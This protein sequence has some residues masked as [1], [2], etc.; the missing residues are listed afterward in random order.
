MRH[1]HD[2]ALTR[3]A[4]TEPQGHPCYRAA[5]ELDASGWAGSTTARRGTCSTSWS[6]RA[7]RATSRTRCC[8]SS[9][10]PVLTLGRHADPAHVLRHGRGARSARHRGH[11]RR[12]RRRGDLSRPGP[13]GRLSHR[14]AG[15]SRPAAAA[16]RA[17]AGA[18]DGRHRR[19]LRR[20][21]RAGA[22]AIPGCWVDPLGPSRRASWAP[23]ACASSAA[24]PT[25]ASRSTSTTDLADFELIDP[26]GL[27]GARGD[28]DRPRAGLDGRPALSPRPTACEAAADRLRAALRARAGCSAGS[29][30][31][32]GPRSARGLRRP[33][34]RRPVRAAPRRHHRL[35]GGGGRR[36]GVRPGAVRDGRPSRVATSDD[37]HCQNCDRADDATASGCACSSRRRSSSPAPS[38]RRATAADAGRGSRSLGPARRRRLVADDRCAPRPPRVA[39]RRDAATIVFEMLAPRP[40]RGRRGARDRPAPSTCQVVQNWGAQAGALTD[41]LCLDFYDLP[42]IPHRIGEELGGAARYLIRE[43]VCPFCRLVRDEVG[44]PR[45]LVFEDAASVCF[46]PYASR[47]PFELWVVPRHHE[48]DFGAATDAQ[49]ASAAETLQSVLRCWTCST[50]RPTTWCCTRRRCSERVD[51]TYHWHWEIHPRLREIAGLEL[52]TGLPVN[53]VSPRRPSRSCWPPRVTRASRCSR[54]AA[55]RSWPACARSAARATSHESSPAVTRSWTRRPVS[56]Q[57]VKGPASR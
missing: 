15:R 1:G 36:S 43:G 57:S 33:M 51:E 44:R 50:A 3:S 20:R 4:Q 27:T 5:M 38:A 34:A 8:C 31:G 46:A 26:C 25:T 2:G 12:A 24:S 40:R 47:S 42:Q 28:L 48:A 6:R 53:P 16:V 11:P 21:R 32:R 30:R 14:A 10:T 52:G 13:A 39:R 23:S 17:R 45:R 49:L 9:T 22:T 19:E 7:P 41:H 56:A 37:G 54:R 29:A 18:G 55:R 35:V